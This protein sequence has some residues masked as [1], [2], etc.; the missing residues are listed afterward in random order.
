MKSTRFSTSK[1]LSEC[2]RE[3]L[4]SIIEKLQDENES[5][6]AKAAWIDGLKKRDAHIIQEEIGKKTVDSSPIVQ[7]TDAQSDLIRERLESV[8]YAVNHASENIFAIDEDGILTFANKQF[9]IDH[10]L[11]ESPFES[12]AYDILRITKL[13]ERWETIKHGI[14]QGGGKY[15]YI[16]EIQQDNRENIW[17]E[18]AVHSEIDSKGHE[19]FWFFARNVTI[20]C[21]QEA[22]IRE[23]NTLM[24]AILNN[25]PVYLFVKDTGDDFRYLYWNKAFEDHSGISASKAVGSTDFDIF[26]NHQDA[27]K[28]RNDDLELIHHNERVEF[29]ENYSATDGEQRVVKTVKLL[30]E[31]ENNKPL[32]IGV[33]WD[34]TDIKKTEEE[35]IEAKLEAEKSNRLKSTFLAN[36]SH[37][38]RTPLNAIVG[39]SQLISMCEDAEERQ[40]FAAIIDSNADLLLQ[41]I[42]DIL[43]ISKIEA[44]TLEFVHAK[45]NMHE[46]C[47]TM[48]EIHRIKMK[49]GVKLIYDRDPEEITFTCD[50]NRLS[51]VFTNLL[52]N[53]TKFTDSGEIR[54]GYRMR[55]THIEAFVKDTG[56]GISPENLNSIFERFVKLNTFAQGT[57][58]GLSITKMIIEKIGGTIKAS[59]ER[60]VGTEFI[61]TIPL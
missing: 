40:E 28:F 9:L 4:L 52:T 37:E 39:F 24:N 45:M 36:M 35:L 49:P 8:N 23:L 60:G 3:E 38:I 17:Y 61:F 14:Q 57:G 44:G 33:S 10:N 42:N 29:L 15:K 31:R 21:K 18:V 20:R 47:N 19:T 41:L 2:G 27:Q 58:L 30:V 46:L 43:D 48:Y 26:P 12:Y 51:Q 34:I 11:L 6:L 5:L 53:A 50:R 1:N 55:E 25:I 7:H 13:K 59:S 54:F 56:I 16:A 32:L 22:R